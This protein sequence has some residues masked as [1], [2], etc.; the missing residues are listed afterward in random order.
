MVRGLLYHTNKIDSGRFARNKIANAAATNICPNKG[1][2]PENIPI[3]TAKETLRWVKSHNSGLWSSFPKIRSDFLRRM[4]SGVGKYLSKKCFIICGDGT[5]YRFIRVGFH[6][7]YINVYVGSTHASTVVGWHDV[8]TGLACPAPT[9]LFNVT[10]TEK[11]TVNLGQLTKMYVEP[12]SPIRYHLCL[13]NDRVALE[14]YIG[15]HFSLRHTGVILCLSCGKRTPKS[16][17]QGYCFPCMRRLACCDLCIVRPHTCHYDK[18]TC[19]E[20]NWGEKHCMTDHIV[21][22]ANTSNIKV[23]LTRFENQYTRWADQGATQ[24]LPIIKTRTRQLA[25]FVEVLL[26]KHVSDKTAWRALVT[27]QAG[28]V[29][30]VEYWNTELHPKVTEP[31]AALASKYSNAFEL[32]KVEPI[33]LSY[34]IVSYPSSS[35]TLSFDTTAHIEGQLLGIKG[36]YLLFDT[37]AL[38]IRKFSGYEVEVLT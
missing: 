34:P 30:L 33:S 2:Q 8:E 26:G 7:R 27:G 37:G 3:A 20:P 25:G 6:I 16:Y 14:P 28:D 38:N 36:Q 10:H 29:D 15:K 35:K 23:G 24:A 9:V 22:L 21:Y 1:N 19:R 18:G 31:L 17:S 11:T 12:A 32:L 13:G 4:L 5:I